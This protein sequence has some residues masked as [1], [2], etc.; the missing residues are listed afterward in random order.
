ML[1]Q[2]KPNGIGPVIGLEDHDIVF[3]TGQPIP[4]FDLQDLDRELVALDTQRNRRAEYPLSTLGS[5]KQHRR[6][7]VLQPQ[8]A[9]E[10]GHPEHMVGVIVGEKNLAKAEADTVAHHLALASL[11]T[12]EEDGLALP[13]YGETG[14]VPVDG[15]DGRAGAQEGDAQHVGEDTARELLKA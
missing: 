15:G 2:R 3:V 14:H 10:T 5:V 4:R 13:L 1:H 8:G 12:I 7:P 6:R 11:S 9:Q